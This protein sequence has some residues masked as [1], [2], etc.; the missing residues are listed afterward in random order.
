MDFIGRKNELEK[1]NAFYDDEKTN[2]AVVYGREGMGK[3]TLISHFLE[4][5]KHISFFAYPTTDKEELRL[6]AQAL[7]TD[8][9]EN[10]DEICAALD[11]IGPE[12]TVLFI[13]H[14]PDFV[15][16]EDSYEKKLFMYMQKPGCHIKLI[17]C[18]DTYLHMEKYVLSKKAVWKEM[19]LCRIEVHGMGYY[20]SSRFFENAS[21]EDKA[22]FYGITGGI[23]KRL[24]AIAG[25]SKQEAVR[26]LYFTENSR[27]LYS[28]EKTM[29]KE[30][31]ELSYYNRMLQT[32]SRGLNRVNQIS[33]EIQ[34]PKDIVVPYL[35]TLMAIGMVT[36][37]NPVTEKTN[38][39]KTRY[40]IINNGD[41]F[42]YRFV[43]NHMDWFDTKNEEAFWGEVEVQKNRYMKQVFTDMCR[44]YLLR[45]SLYQRLPFTVDEIGNW[46]IND[47][48]KKTTEGFDLVALG[49]SE[50]RE[51]TIYGRVDYSDDPIEIMELKELIGMT[52]KMPRKGDV[53][54]VIFSK[55]GFHENAE[56]V[57]A[58][59]KNILL[60]TLEDISMESDV[61]K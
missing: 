52:R 6:F 14:Y 50:G 30:L 21:A 24:A 54:Y 53:F 19:E 61:K 59:I 48:E 37:E 40:S 38:R 23:P 28:P 13:D 11:E 46:W 18:G 16:A 5:K 51:A 32:L 57:A 44:E 55:A 34:K 12:K 43:A 17:L 58:T 20:D 8:A 49:S 10:M 56:T 22:F 45:E 42:W 39:K 2:V 35:N 47:D 3:T 29:G 4:D 36:K 26:T 27:A 1:L 31:R 25:M 7:Q 41:V 9:P 33:E 60:I 15:K